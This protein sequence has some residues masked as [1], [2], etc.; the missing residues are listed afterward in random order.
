MTISEKH[1]CLKYRFLSSRE[2]VGSWG[3]EYCKHLTSELT[4]TWNDLEEDVEKKAARAA[5]EL[6]KSSASTAATAEA[7]TASTQDVELTIEPVV[8]IT[9]ED[10]LPLAKEI[11]A[12]YMKHNAEADACDLLMEIEH[13]SLL[14][15]FVEKET[16][17][18]VCLYL[19]SCAPYVPEPED[20]ILLK[21][22][23]N[24]YLKFQQDQLALRCAIQLND[25]NL[26]HEVFYNCKDRLTY[27]NLY[28][29]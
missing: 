18:R 24:M 16:Y 21:E 29:S 27:I 9:K 26:I 7:D 19:L 5:A 8:K 6:A 3:T 14:S 11:V 20:S 10:L 22:A 15:D 1:E 17:Q 12:F 13:V 4:Q 2:T 23:Y 28:N 25:Q